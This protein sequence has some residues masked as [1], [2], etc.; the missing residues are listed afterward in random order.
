MAIEIS[1]AT[2]IYC[3]IFYL[4]S[5]YMHSSFVALPIKRNLEERRKWLQYI[6]SFSM[7]S[8]DFIEPCSS[9]EVAVC[10]NHFIG[11]V[12]TKRNPYPVLNTP[13]I[14]E[15]MKAAMRKVSHVEPVCVF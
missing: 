14:S 15:S 9:D 7:E 3:V 6:G 1:I 8:G 11:G 2:I 13:T 10:S 12:P 4:Y 5:H